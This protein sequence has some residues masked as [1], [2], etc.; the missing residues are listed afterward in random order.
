[1]LIKENHTIL[2]S[3]DFSKQSLF[4]IK[5]SYN[6]AKHTKSKLLLFYVSTVSETDRADELK[7]IAEETSKES[8]LVVDSM[9]AKGELYE[10]LTK[11]AEDLKLSL[12]VMG[13]DDNVRFKSR[14]GG[15]TI[16]KFINTLSCP[17]LTM[18]EAVIRDGVK[19]IVMPFDLSPESREKV[20]FAVQLSRYY[21][22]DIRIVSVFPPNDD[23]YENKLLP[24]LQQVKK[25]IKTEGINCTNKS[26]PSTTAAEA[27][28]EYA[29]ANECDLLIQ[30]NQK[31][32]SFSEMF[33]GTVGQR[34]LEIS[35]IPVL[36]INPMKRESMSHFGSGM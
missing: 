31:D 5:H 25:F 36:T 17:I 6:I 32:L 26:I 16:H 30:M 10:V 9:V 34:I 7:K 33:S 14:F 15:M 1:M 23:S 35:K 24:Y 11:K 8:G 3:I 4:A 19:N 12:I 13:L 18:R 20:S 21:T 29:T 28:L 27:I 2:I 22:S